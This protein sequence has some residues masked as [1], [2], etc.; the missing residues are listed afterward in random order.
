M[1]GTQ[2]PLSFELL[3]QT[4]QHELEDARSPKGLGN[5]AAWKLLSTLELLFKVRHLNAACD[6]GSQEIREH[7]VLIESRA[8]RGLHPV[9]WKKPEVGPFEGNRS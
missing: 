1:H 7:A 2:L 3:I 8:P 4:L 5:R 6:V 9:V